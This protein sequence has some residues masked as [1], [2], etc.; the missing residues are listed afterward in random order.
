MIGPSG[1]GKSTFL[2]AIGLLDRGA[3]RGWRQGRAEGAR[4]RGGSASTGRRSASSAR[5]AA[6]R[7]ATARSASCSRPTTCSPST[8]PSAT[9]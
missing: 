2:H 9:S 5:R 7:C 3:E 1:S 8:P 4:T 6:P